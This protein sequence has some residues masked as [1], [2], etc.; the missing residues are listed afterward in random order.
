[1]KYLERGQ[2]LSD[3]QEGATAHCAMTWDIPLLQTLYAPNET[4]N[5]TAYG[6][7]EDFTIAH[8]TITSAEGM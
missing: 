7:H 8:P 4:E 3:S 5:K 6:S 2:Y 1:M